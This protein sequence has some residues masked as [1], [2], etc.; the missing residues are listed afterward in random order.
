M[1]I[2]SSRTEE[3]QNLQEQLSTH[4]VLM[5]LSNSTSSRNLWATISRAS[6]GHAWNQSMVQQLMREGNMRRRFLKASP[7]GL[8]AAG[9]EDVVCAGRV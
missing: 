3:E 4:D 6:S 5:S 2:K 1:K 9:G 8:M 7:M